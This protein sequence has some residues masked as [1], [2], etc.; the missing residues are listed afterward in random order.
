VTAV[1]DI[2]VNPVLRGFNPDP[3]ILR[4]GDDFYIATSTFEW[5]P[6]VAIHHSRDLVHWQLLG[7]ALTRQTQLDMRGN[8]NSGG[9]W[10]PCL[11]YADGLFHLIFTDV[12]SRRGAFKDT[13]NYLVTAPSIH[14]PWSDPVYLNSSGFDPS[15]FHAPDGRKYLLN[16]IWD[17]RPDRNSFGGIALQEYDPGQHRLVGPAA[18]IFGGTS[19]G[20]TEGPHLYFYGGY[21]YLIVA[22]GGTKYDHAVTIARST[23]IAGPYEADPSGPMLTSAGDPS[24]AL[25]KAGHGSLVQTQ[26]GEWYLAHLCGRPTVGKYCMMGRETALQRCHWTEDGWLRL[27]NGGQAPEMTVSAP[28]LPPTPF[29]PIPA[30]DHF[31]GHRLS[32]HWSTL[33]VPPDPSW[34]SL[35]ERPGHLRLKGRESLSSLHH[36]SLVAQRQRSFAF[37]AE[38]AMEFEPDH[39]QQAAGLILFYDTDDYVYLRI[40]HAEGIGRVLGIVQSVSGHYS[41][42][43]ESQVS[44]PLDLGVSCGLKAIVRGPTLQFSFASAGSLW[45]DI[46][47]TIDIRHLSDDFVEPVRFT[48]NFVGICAQDL[49]GTRKHADFDYFSY[50]DEDVIA[51]PAHGNESRERDPQ[52]PETIHHHAVQSRYITP[53]T[54]YE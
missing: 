23:S 26:A 7:H 15:L 42:L 43:P 44:L 36:Q 21:F 10:A 50:W 48:G 13:H 16:M 22:E 2:I 1:N 40:S 20:F 45:R 17:H 47:P 9:V 37:T 24:L 35:S 8:V 53:R 6:G 49:A 51:W 39:F 25:Q 18:N 34:L 27:A 31:G 14:G 38:T 4:V 32:P 28:K 3:S 41:E 54:K 30:T 5:S 33:R 29:S 19:L 46:G 12:K 52:S 11:S